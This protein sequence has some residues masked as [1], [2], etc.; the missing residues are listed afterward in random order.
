MVTEGE[1]KKELA[2]LLVYGSKQ[3]GLCILGS[4]APTI[5]LGLNELRT[6]KP[7]RQEG[8][9]G[10]SST[11]GMR[12]RQRKKK[13]RRCLG[14]RGRL[15]QIMDGSDVAATRVSTHLQQGRYQVHTGE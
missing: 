10:I 4:Y 9:T 14:H 8:G 15:D 13:E 3:T 7:Y 1:R 2:S 6:E 12:D 11:E 5:Y